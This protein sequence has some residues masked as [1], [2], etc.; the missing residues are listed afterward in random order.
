MFGFQ[1]TPVFY[2]YK[3]TEFG[4]KKVHMAL[5]VLETYF[6][7]LGTM[8]AA[9]NHLTIADFPLINTNMTLEAIDFDFSKYKRVSY[10]LNSDSQN[11]HGRMSIIW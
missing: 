4:L 6:E 2:D 9:A 1:I 7:R 5:E 10:N 3:R 8:Y 11:K